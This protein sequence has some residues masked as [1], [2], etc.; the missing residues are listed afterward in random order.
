MYATF[1]Y[2]TKRLKRGM[3]AKLA[4]ASPRFEP[5]LATPAPLASMEFRHQQGGKDLMIFLPG[6]GDLAE[7]FE[8]QGFIDDMW[9]HGMTAD[10]LALDA[11]YGYYARRMIHDR[12]A[13]DAILRGRKA[14]Y[15][16]IWLAGVSLGGF[17]A[18][19]YAARFP[20]HVHGLVLLAPYLGDDG[21]IRE[22]GS[23]GGLQEWKPGA[24]AE[25][26]YPRVLWRW[27]KRYSS[28]SA[29]HPRIYL[30]YGAG[31]R[32]ATANALLGQVLPARQVFAIP[33]KHDW[34]TWQRIWK[35]FL[36]QRVAP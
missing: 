33:G 23:A 11:H 17:G 18:A 22:I 20:S 26:D 35:L 4:L 28:Q 2:R 29:P 14:G 1:K 36:A 30:G 27:L 32:F 12:M 25:D 10:A 24:I 34:E 13:E 5:L 7:D 3:L 21:L 6:I 19:S 9:E 15:E 16:R 8:R 31:D